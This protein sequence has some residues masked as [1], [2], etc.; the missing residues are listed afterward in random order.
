[1]TT[2]EEVKA[3]VAHYDNHREWHD[4]ARG[5]GNLGDGYYN[6]SEGE[7]TNL[8]IGFPEACRRMTHYLGVLGQL[9]ADSLVLDLGCGEGTPAINMAKQFGNLTIF[10]FCSNLF[11]TISLH[12]KISMPGFHESKEL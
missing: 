4:L 11:H 12:K 9:A 8:N 5:K 10:S 1:M 6:F 7:P 2:V 3:I